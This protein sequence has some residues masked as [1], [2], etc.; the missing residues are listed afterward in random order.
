PRDPGAVLGEGGEGAVGAVDLGVRLDVAGVVA[1][2]VRGAPHE[3]PLTVPVDVRAGLGRAAHSA[4]ADPE[5]V[6]VAGA[7]VV[8]RVV[9]PAVVGR[10]VG[11]DD[12]RAPPPEVC[13]G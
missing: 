5:A 3:A 7:D 11:V 8:A 10:A 4:P 2:A 9:V 6:E 1:A 12:L 13:L